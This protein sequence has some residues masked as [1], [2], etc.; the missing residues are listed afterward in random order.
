MLVLSLNKNTPLILNVETETQ[1]K[2][3]GINNERVLYRI[4]FPYVQTA[5]QKRI[6]RKTVFKNRNSVF[7][8]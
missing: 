2:V 3:L 8:Q 4:E 1:I 7:H 5:F 6:I